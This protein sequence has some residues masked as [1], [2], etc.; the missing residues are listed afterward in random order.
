MIGVMH[1]VSDPKLGPPKYIVHCEHKNDCLIKARM[2]VICT[3]SRRPRPPEG[4]MRVREIS[5]PE[6]AHG[7]AAYYAIS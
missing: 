7:D 5:L 2:E 3:A 6:I 4:S 1:D